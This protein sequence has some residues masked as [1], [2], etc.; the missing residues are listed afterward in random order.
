MVTPWIYQ[1]ATQVFS[2]KQLECCGTLPTSQP[3]LVSGFL[4]HPC[5]EGA[6]HNVLWVEK[7]WLG[8]PGHYSAAV[9]DG[10]RYEVS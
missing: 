4:H 7:S 1:I 8:I 9:L 3:S 2:E 6:I 5:H 10:V